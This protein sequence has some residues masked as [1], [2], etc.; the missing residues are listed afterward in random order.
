MKKFIAEKGP[1]A[2]GPYS[3]AVQ[4]GDL[5][6]CSGMVGSDPETGELKEGVEAQALRAL[7]NM[8]IVLE[9]AGYSINDVAKTIVFLDNMDDFEKINKVYGDFFGEHKPARSCVEVARLPKGALF[10]VE[11]VASK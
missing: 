9:D 8:K 11:C 6:F 1:K 2:V 3:H 5:I 4:V 7:E 10:E